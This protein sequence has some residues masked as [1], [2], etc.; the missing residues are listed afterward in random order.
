[1]KIQFEILYGLAFV[2]IFALFAFKTKRTDPRYNGFRLAS[3][4]GLIFFLGWLTLAIFE[5]YERYNFLQFGGYALI[6]VGFAVGLVG[7]KK[8]ANTVFNPKLFDAKREVDPGYDVPYKLCPNCKKIEIRMYYKKMKC[9]NC[10][11]FIREK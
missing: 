8:H 10:G 5:N 2:A 1:M 6:F 3:K 7:F 11:S 4:G 9:P